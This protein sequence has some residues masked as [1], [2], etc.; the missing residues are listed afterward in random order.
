MSNHVAFRHLV[1]Q[2][3]ATGAVVAVAQTASAQALPPRP[4]VT[5]ARDLLEPPPQRVSV[6]TAMVF[7]IRP[8]AAARRVATGSLQVRVFS[9]SAGLTPQPTRVEGDCN[10][11][12]TRVFELQP[13]ADGGLRFA[14][15]DAAWL[16]L[17]RARRSVTEGRYLLVVEQE[18]DHDGE[19]RLSKR[20]TSGYFATGFV[21]SVSPS[22]EAR[23]M[24]PDSGAQEALLRATRVAY[25]ARRASIA[26]IVGNGEA[27]GRPCYRYSAV[28]VAVLSN[29]GEEHSGTLDACGN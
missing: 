17:S 14:T 29:V 9:L 28:R 16:N 2:S 6:G 3:I 20:S 18:G 13:T 21:V 11:Y 8:T 25:D 4:T 7:R 12:F 10:V 15:L 27:V 22:M 26:S 24:Y 19:F 5:H 23:S 1:L